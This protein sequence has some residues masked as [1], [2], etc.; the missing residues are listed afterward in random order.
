MLKFVFGS[1]IE[2]QNISSIVRDA[3]LLDQIDKSL[4]K[5]QGGILSN[6]QYYK[7]SVMPG[8]KNLLNTSD[9]VIP[10]F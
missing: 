9:S 1:N 5:N 8:P 2:S 3:E 4:K 6:F 7:V 10:F